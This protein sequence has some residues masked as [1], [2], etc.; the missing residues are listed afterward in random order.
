VVL[1]DVAK[2]AEQQ[3]QILL[4]AVVGAAIALEGLYSLDRIRVYPG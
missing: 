4:R 3:Q 2:V 1:V